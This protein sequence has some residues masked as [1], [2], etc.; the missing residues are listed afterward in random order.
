MPII[1][2]APA[3]YTPPPPDGLTGYPVD[4]DDDVGPRQA[5]LVTIT[6]D[7]DL[8][9]AGLPGFISAGTWNIT[10]NPGPLSR[11]ATTVGIRWA[12]DGVAKFTDCDINQGTDAQFIFFL[13]PGFSDNRID[14]QYCNFRRG[15]GV[16]ASQTASNGALQ[17]NG[18]A[19]HYLFHCDL[20][21]CP[22]HIQGAAFNM[23]WCYCHDPIFGSEAHVD[24]ADLDQ[25][26]T[27]IENSNIIIP[28]TG[29]VNGAVWTQWDE[30]SYPGGGITEVVDSR[31]EGGGFT[32]HSQGGLIRCTRTRIGGGAFG[33]KNGSN[34]GSVE[35]VDCTALDGVTPIS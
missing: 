8:S 26:G 30:G 3:D 33:N 1:L 4:S 5:A 23:V 32:V 10:S 28:N 9:S 11:V 25:S 20:S 13:A 35:L 34:G 21:G 15:S 6:N 19:G 17:L 2:N 7:A 12:C 24:G 22:D 16:I 14:M 29:P 27:V 31:L 18:G